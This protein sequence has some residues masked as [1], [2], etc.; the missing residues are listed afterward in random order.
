MN[1][2]FKLLDKYYET[3]VVKNSKNGNWKGGTYICGGYVKV[4]VKSHPMA[5]KRNL[6]VHK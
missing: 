2:R 3:E 4:K 5:D 1:D 6:G